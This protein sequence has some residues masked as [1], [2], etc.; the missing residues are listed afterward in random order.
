MTEKILPATCLIESIDPDA[1]V[2]SPQK[3]ANMERGSGDHRV[4][5]NSERKVSKALLGL[6]MNGESVIQHLVINEPNSDEDRQKRDIDA[7]VGDKRYGIQVKSCDAEMERALDEIEE[8]LK[9]KGESNPSPTDW[10]LTN[11]LI[12]LNG[13]LSL[14]QIGGDFLFQ[15]RR[16]QRFQGLAISV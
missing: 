3:I 15:L 9:G 4:G 10:M 2:L 7:W 1:S 8:E 12:L 16:I 5:R 14:E 6:K 13:R 11:G